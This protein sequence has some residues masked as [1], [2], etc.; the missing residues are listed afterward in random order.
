MTPL[1]SVVAGH[2]ILKLMTSPKVFPQLQNQFIKAMFPQILLA[3]LFLVMISVH[4]MRASLS[5][6]PGGGLTLAHLRV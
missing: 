6:Y 3:N 4:A 1:S 2:F 5:Q